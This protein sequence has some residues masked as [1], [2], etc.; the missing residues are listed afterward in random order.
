MIDEKFIN[1]IIKRIFDKGYDCFTSEAQLRDLFAIEV[2]LIDSDMIVMP[3]YTQEVPVGWRCSEKLVHF[4]LLIVDKKNNEKILIEFKY[5]TA[6]G[7]FNTK[8]GMHIRLSD[9]SDSTNGRYAVW[10]D[11]YRIETFSNLRHIDKGFVIFI[12]NYKSYYA[13]PQKDSISEEFSISPKLHIAANKNWNIANK[14]TNS[15]SVEY[16]KDDKP[17]II[18]NDYRFI[19]RQYSLIN[20][21]SL[22]NHEFRILIVPIYSTDYHKKLVRQLQSIGKKNFVEY[23]DLLKD[24]NSP[25]NKRALVNANFN[26][27][28]VDTIVSHARNIF[29]NKKNIEALRIIIDSNKVDSNLRN[30]ATQLLD[31][32]LMSQQ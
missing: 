2:G 10:R 23:Y 8:N 14:S 21:I 7:E 12:T 11:I 9:N 25:Q 1:Q 30:K 29:L 24:T 26:K 31:K 6:K 17:L 20:D 18:S 15:I 27:S 32:E 22:K 16:R 13:E 19:Y 5:K 28:S 3:E 4:D